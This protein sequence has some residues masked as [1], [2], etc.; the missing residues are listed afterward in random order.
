M[1][2]DGD[3]GTLFLTREE[4]SSALLMAN[5]G[6]LSGM[7]TRARHIKELCWQLE[8]LP[9]NREGTITVSRDVLRMRFYWNSGISARV[10]DATRKAAE[11]LGIITVGR[12]PNKTGGQGVNHYQVKWSTIQKF[13]HPSTAATRSQVPTSPQVATSCNALSPQAAPQT[14][15]QTTPAPRDEPPLPEGVGASTGGGRRLCT[16]VEAI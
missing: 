16:P 9:V 6:D 10:F 5:F 2:T 7:H 12:S 11:D 1:A 15:P 13:G 8:M 14:E 3:Q 4:K